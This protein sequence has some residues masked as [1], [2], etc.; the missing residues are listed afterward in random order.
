E[1]PD[2]DEHEREVCDH[3]GFVYYQNPKVVVGAV[4]TYEGRFLMCRRAIDPG[5]GLWT[6]PAG[7]MELNETCEQAAQ[8][9]AREEANAVIALDGVLAIYTLQHISQVQIFYQARLAEPAISPGAESLEVGLYAWDDIPWAE[10][11]FPS[12]HWVLYHYREA[13][14]KDQTLPFGNP[15]TP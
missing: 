6:I 4:A 15:E 7:F 5:R 11:A 8:R 1:T 9:E 10:I 3:C 2:Q 14:R 13:L 12:V